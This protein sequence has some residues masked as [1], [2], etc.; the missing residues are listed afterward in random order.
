MAM[1]PL[2]PREIAVLTAVVH[3]HTESAEPVG[4]RTIARQ[5]LHDLSPATIRNTMMDLEDIGFLHSPHTSAG[6]EP[7]ARAYRYYLDEVME[8]A[9]LGRSDKSVF[10]ELLTE[11]Q[12][13]R[14]ADVVLSCVS[15]AL[16][17]VSRLITVAFLP[18]FDN[19]VLRRIELVSL[20]E[21]RILV[22]LEIKG[23][24]VHTLTLEMDEPVA[25]GL[26]G[27]TARILNERLSGLTIGQIRASITERLSGIS[28][29]EQHVI[30]VFLREGSD[31]FDLDSRTNVHLEGR[32]NILAQPE[33]SDHTRLMQFM[34]LLDEKALIQ[35]LRRRGASRRTQVSIGTEN[36]LPE[37]ADCSLLTRGYR[38]GSL[39]GTL[40]IVG[41]MRMPYRRLV[42]VLEHAGGVAETLMS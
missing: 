12:C 3:A 42:A 28:G 15:R 1:R 7:T 25:Q 36:S 18:T 20:G 32:P 35:E 5:Y 16:A 9:R 14:D 34:R 17:R 31:I 21:S 10:D 33:F 40:A 23:G 24:P 2:T 11:R 27:E 8:P 29:G 38:A 26:I 6:R 22:A 30:N 39:S 37:L 41:P 13:A 4:S 19:G